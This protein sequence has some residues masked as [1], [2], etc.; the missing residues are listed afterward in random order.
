MKI[1][2]IGDSLTRGYPH[3]PGHDFPHILQQ[4]Y[5][6]PNGGPVVTV[7][8]GV[9]GET[10]GEILSRVRK[11][12]YHLIEGHIATIIAGSNDFIFDLRNPREVLKQ[13]LAIA[14]ICQ[15][16]GLKP[17]LISPTKTNPVEAER[18]WI[19]GDNTDYN[20]VNQNIDHLRDLLKEAAEEF[21]Y[22]FLD[23]DPEYR[24]YGKFVDGLHPTEEGYQLIAKIIANKLKLVKESK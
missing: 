11:E 3:G 21:G 8:L 1:I 24:E 20:K 13:N 15:A 19:T 9:S 18:F 2:C 14:A 22:G 16:K 6:E 10:S 5:K 23:L 4:K 12:E 17:Y 7:N